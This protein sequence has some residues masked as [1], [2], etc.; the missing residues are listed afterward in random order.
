METI[1]NEFTLDLSGG[2]PLS[3]DSMVLAD[4]VKLPKNASVLD[5]GS[6]CA[7]LGLLLCARDF[8]S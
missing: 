6:G 3:T 2:F 5:L 8:F 4:F 7:T 1:N